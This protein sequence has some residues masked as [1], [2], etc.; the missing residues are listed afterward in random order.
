M[1]LEIFK[2]AVLILV[3]AVA[4]TGCVKKQDERTVQSEEELQTQ[5][6]PELSQNTVYQEN[7]PDWAKNPDTSFE[8]GPDNLQA[9]S[10]EDKLFAE[11]V[12][13]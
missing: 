2:P 12:G 10:E 7:Q 5:D 13:D 3:L 6:L 1:K 9:P 8:N 11:P 4:F